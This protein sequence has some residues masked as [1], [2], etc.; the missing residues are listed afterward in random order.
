M[1][2]I[3]AEAAAKSIGY[4]IG[5]GSLILYTPIAIRIFRQKHAN[6]LVISTWWLKLCSYILSD[7]Y[8]TRYVCIMFFK[9][10]FSFLLFIYAIPMSGEQQ[11][12][13]S[14]RNILLQFNATD[15]LVSTFL[16]F[17][18]LTLT[19]LHSLLFFS[20]SKKNQNK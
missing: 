20:N 2:F 10:F 14:Y 11:T 5:F 3:A 15:S 1:T 16:P 19:P 8:Y 13:C 12:L 17:F 6:G 4:L 9:F 18:A 7:I